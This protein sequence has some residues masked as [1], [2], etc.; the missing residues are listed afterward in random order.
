MDIS[1]FSFYESTGLNLKS[2]FVN[3]KFTKKMR[4]IYFV[5][6]LKYRT[7][8]LLAIKSYLCKVIN[9]LS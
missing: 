3:Y 1:H 5:F 7:F 8:N 4:L 9:D 2:I 6:H